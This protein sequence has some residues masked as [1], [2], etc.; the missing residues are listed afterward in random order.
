MALKPATSLNLWV[1]TTILLVIGICLVYSWTCTLM[2][3]GC[4]PTGVPAGSNS[5][6][7]AGGNRTRNCSLLSK[8][9]SNNSR[10]ASLKS[11]M[12]S[13]SSGNPSLSSEMVGNR[14]SESRERFELGGRLVPYVTVATWTMTNT[15]CNCS[16]CS[17]LSIHL[18]GYC[19]SLATQCTCICTPIL[20]VATVLA[21]LLVATVLA[22]I[23]IHDVVRERRV[24]TTKRKLLKGS[25]VVHHIHV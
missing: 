3:K 22:L 24:C 19:D 11:D 8:R 16:H 9:I 15:P 23:V 10:N 25:R 7:S 17:P 18:I 14:S 4:Q 12:I 13:N 21:L 1:A 2:D 5:L 6:Q 20:L